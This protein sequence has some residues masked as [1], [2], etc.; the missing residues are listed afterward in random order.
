V[1]ERP[2][3]DRKKEGFASLSLKNGQKVAWAMRGSRC[4]ERSSSRQPLLIRVTDCPNRAGATLRRGYRYK[5]RDARGH[6]PV[7]ENSMQMPKPEAGNH[8][9]ILRLE[10][11][12]APTVSELVLNKPAME[13]GVPHWLGRWLGV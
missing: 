13:V 7:F 12:A 9:A 8:E 1:K 2:E 6:T 10:R 5:K 4:G 3:S 11:V